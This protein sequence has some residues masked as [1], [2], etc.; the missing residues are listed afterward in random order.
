M[1]NIKPSNRTIDQSDKEHAFR[2]HRIAIKNMKS[3]VNSSPPTQYKFLS[4]KKKP[5]KI[6]EGTLT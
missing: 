4:K 6:S 1:W 5:K 3:L 2:R